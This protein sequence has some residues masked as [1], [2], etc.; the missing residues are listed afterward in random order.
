MKPVCYLMLKTNQIGCFFGVKN[1]FQQDVNKKKLKDYQKI[2]AQAKKS[3]IGESNESWRANKPW[4]NRLGRSLAKVPI[5][6]F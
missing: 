3:L 4:C 2:K 1:K 5:K 6:E